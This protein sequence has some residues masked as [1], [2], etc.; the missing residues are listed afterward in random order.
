MEELV[1]RKCGPRVLCAELLPHHAWE[2]VGQMTPRSALL[3]GAV[4]GNIHR[5]FG[6]PRE[7]LVTGRLNF[8]TALVFFPLT[9]VVLL[10][11]WMGE[12]AAP[13]VAGGR[14]RWG[15]CLFI[16]EQPMSLT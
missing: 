11:G 14:S 2:D 15:W 12:E 9:A 3:A 6:Q 16:T 8:C 7:Q 4:Y 10:E 5:G 1:A 13:L